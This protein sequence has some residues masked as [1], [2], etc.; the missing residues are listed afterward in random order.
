MTNALSES[1]V[2]ELRGALETRHAQ[3]RGEITGL[4]GAEG[5][6]GSPMADPA[7]DVRGD[8]ADQSVDQQSW[9]TERQVE[10]DQRDQLAEVEHALT[11]FA[12]GTYGVCEQ[13]GQPIPL[14]RLRIIP[15][16]RYDA[17]HQ[18]EHDARAAR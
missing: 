16:A 1:E 3:L 8:L 6:T 7:A 5:A 11:K 17:A 9:D 2:A 10:L 18:A 15:E 12:A 13:C 14:A 4:R